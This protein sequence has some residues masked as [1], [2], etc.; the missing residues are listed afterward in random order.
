MEG[1]DNAISCLPFQILWTMKRQ[2]WPRKVEVPRGQLASGDGKFSF[3]GVWWIIVGRG[4]RSSVCT[5]V[6][7]SG[8][9]KGR[10]VSAGA[11]RYS[12]CSA[13]FLIYFLL[14][15]ISFRNCGPCVA[16]FVDALIRR[17]RQQ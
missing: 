6:Q 11:N 13:C 1:L 7:M 8:Y 2:R 12:G 10:C 14:Q 15:I 3:E 4:E 5:F 16:T 17:H 9:L